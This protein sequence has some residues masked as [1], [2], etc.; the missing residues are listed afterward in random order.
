[1]QPGRTIK[2]LV[3]LVQERDTAACRELFENHQPAVFGYCLAFALG[4]ETLAHE[5]S[6]E[7]WVTAF[8]SIARLRDRARFVEWLD[9]VTRISCMRVLEQRRDRPRDNVPDVLVEMIATCPNL[10]LQEVAAAAYD[11]EPS[12]PHAIA[13]ELGIDPDEVAGRLQ[14]FEAWVRPQLVARLVQAAEDEQ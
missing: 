4:N 13:Q 6:V 11:D 9:A 7:A 8:G 14:R 5:L 12:N 1:M 2:E 3:A 10:G